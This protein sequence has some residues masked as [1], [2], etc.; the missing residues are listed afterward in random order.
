MK[1]AHHPGSMVMLGGCEV[2][3]IASEVPGTVES[4]RVLAV[5]VMIQLNICGSRNL[6]EPKRTKWRYFF[7]MLYLEF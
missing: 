5:A 4:V 7:D 1:R 3:P 6:K 2:A